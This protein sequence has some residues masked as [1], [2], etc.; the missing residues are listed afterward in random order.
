MRSKAPGTFVLKYLSALLMS[1]ASSDRF[2]VDVF[3][4]IAQV[5]IV[6]MFVVTTFDCSWIVFYGVDFRHATNHVMITEELRER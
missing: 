5:I 4:I 1:H 2:P 6:I 3:D